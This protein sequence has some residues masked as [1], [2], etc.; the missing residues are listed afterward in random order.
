MTWD[1][2]S[3]LPLLGLGGVVAV[4]GASF[5]QFMISRPL[6][7]ATLAGWVAGD[8]AAGAMVGVL[9]EAFDLS[10]L[11]VGAARYP[12]GGPSA[13]VAGAAFAASP[14]ETPALLAA[15]L[16]FVAWEWIG[17]RSVRLLRQLN[18]RLLTSETRPI[19]APGVLELRQLAGIL[20]DFGR[21][22]LLVALGLAL[23]GAL[24]PLSVRFWGIGGQVSQWVAT[25]VLTALLA[26]TLHLFSGRGRWF[27]TGAMLGLLLLLARS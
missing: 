18:G 17:G 27:A 7:A 26:G 24:L 13:V 12:E 2:G 3:W 22:V 19:R 5:G 10:V 9:L 15:V 20:F 14:Q 4:D 11:P 6:I 1:A 25:G 8:P 23:L 16:F 21:G